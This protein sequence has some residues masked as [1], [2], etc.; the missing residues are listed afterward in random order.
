MICAQ[1]DKHVIENWKALGFEQKRV[2]FPGEGYLNAKEVAW[3]G[4]RFELE[5]Y[6]REDNESEK[7]VSTSSFLLFQCQMYSQSIENAPPNP[8]A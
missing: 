4:N 7:K 8:Q 2:K 3:S 1:A 5:R 6:H